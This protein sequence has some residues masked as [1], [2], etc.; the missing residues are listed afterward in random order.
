MMRK[1]ITNS[2]MHSNLQVLCHC[3]V[4]LVV[5]TVYIMSSIHVAMKVVMF[6]GATER[7]HAGL[8]TV[9]GNQLCWPMIPVIIRLPCDHPG[10]VQLL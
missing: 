3:K 6:L 10:G 4:E 5:C 2:V 7:T 8:H 9:S 1:G